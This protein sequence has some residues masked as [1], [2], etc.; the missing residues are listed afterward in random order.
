MQKE[1]ATTPFN[2][3]KSSHIEVV[4]AIIVTGERI[5]CVKRGKGKHDY[6]SHRYEF[7]GGKV[8]EGETHE[9]ALKRE[10]SEE[11]SIGIEVE[12]FFISTTHSYPDFTITLYAFIC[13]ISQGEITLSEHTEHRWLLP[14]ELKSVVWTDADKEIVEAL[15]KI[16]TN[17]ANYTSA[18][19]VT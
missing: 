10:I 3:E 16:Q 8:E 15:S 17:N 9:Q 12:R 13:K 2:K 5:L 1:T 14:E 4:A 18:N 6:T 19:R 11:L 7:P